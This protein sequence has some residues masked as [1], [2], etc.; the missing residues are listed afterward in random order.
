MSFFNELKRRNVIKVAAAYIIVSWLLLQVSDTLVPALHLPEWF[1]SGVAFVLIIG[2]PIA[3][4]FAWAFEMTPEG[5]KKEKEIDRSQSITKDTGR[6]LDFTIIAVLVIALAYFIYERSNTPG[7]GEP[8]ADSGTATETTIQ[9]SIAVLPFADMSPEGDQAYFSDG[10]A[11]ELLNLLVRVDGLKVASRTSSFSY[12]GGDLNLPEIAEELKVAHILEGS[13]RKSGDRVRIT[14]QLIDTASDR[15]LWSQTYD[16]DLTDIFAIQDD[17]ANAIVDAL[18]TEL[19]LLSAAS[20]ILVKADTENLDAYQLYLEARG[21]FLIRKDLGR[22]IELFKKAIDLDANF[23]RAWEGLGAALSVAEGWGVKGEN[24]EGRARAAAQEAVDLDPSLSMSWATLATISITLDADFSLGMSQFNRAIENDP[25]S[26]TAWFWRGLNYAKLGFARESI[27]D[28]SKCT[29]ID[30]AYL[31]CYR[32]LARAYL[33]NGE[34]DRSLETYFTNLEAGMSINDF[35]LIHPLLTRDKK[36]AAAF[37]LVSE[38]DGDRDYPYEELINAVRYP[39][40][41]H[42]SGISKLTNWSERRGIPLRFRISEWI[43][44]GAWDRVEPSGD[45]HQLWH[46]SGSQFRA[47]PWFKPLAEKMGWPKYWRKHGYPPQ[48]RPVGEEDFECE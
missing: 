20:T 3:M 45:I 7:P 1:H 25:K 22:S 42:S 40:R 29:E 36:F 30:P 35:W 15:H 37:L 16:R 4:I 46:P 47:S 21:L 10:I 18:R 39:E 33:S 24:F 32:H 23:A 8:V 26:A 31:N 11:E 43:A 19:G 27:R 41:D 34:I 44:L 17:I 2:F 12:R 6:K 28:I 14:A 5:L 48:C 38:A 13:V 9:P